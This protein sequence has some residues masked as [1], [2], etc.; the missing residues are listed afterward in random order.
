M[1]NNYE[2]NKNIKHV[3]V[4]INKYVKRARMPRARA[5]YTAKNAKEADA[6]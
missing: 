3:Y 2:Y 6:A 1:K 4:F 5:R